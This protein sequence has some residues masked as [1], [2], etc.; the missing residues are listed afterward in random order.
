M[1]DNSFFLSETYSIMNLT[2]SANADILILFKLEIEKLEIFSTFE[3]T[4]KKFNFFCHYFI[5]LEEKLNSNF[6]STKH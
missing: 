2:K 6:P 5:L 3:K 1:K 4:F